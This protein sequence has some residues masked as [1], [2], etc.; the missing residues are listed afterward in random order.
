MTA[1][2]L[3]GLPSELVQHILAFLQPTDLAIVAQ[4][5]RRLYTESYEDTIWHSKINAYFRAPI[6]KPA[7]TKSFREL[8]VAHHP[9]WFLL[10][11]RLWFG[12]SEP[13]GKLLA[14]K[15]DESTGSINAYTVLVSIALANDTA[16]DC[17]TDQA[18]ALVLNTRHC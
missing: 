10:S 16:G 12:D 9:H 3:L 17:W 6:P 18:Q 8:Y 2:S 11:K 15:Y 5:C 14:A 1:L 13:S 7:T 4:V